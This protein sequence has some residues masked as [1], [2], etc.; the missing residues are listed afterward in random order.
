MRCGP[1]ERGRNFQEFSSSCAEAGVDRDLGA[2]N[3]DSRILAFFRWTSGQENSL[4]GPRACT[5]QAPLITIDAAGA[6]ARQALS[7]LAAA[8]EHVELHDYTWAWCQ[9]SSLA[10]FDPPFGTFLLV[11][12]AAST[13]EAM[14]LISRTLS[15]SDDARFRLLISELAGNLP[16]AEHLDRF[17]GI[18]SACRATPVICLGGSGMGPAE[19][20]QRVLSALLLSLINSSYGCVDWDDFALMFQ[21]VPGGYAVATWVDQGELPESRIC[22]DSAIALEARRPAA[23]VKSSFCCRI[24]KEGYGLTEWESLCVVLDQLAFSDP[25]LCGAALSI[26]K[27]AAGEAGISAGLCLLEVLI[28]HH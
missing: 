16:V 9:P 7:R 28:A 27:A 11:D 1:S 4:L 17:C 15:V 21:R 20:G 13:D 14:A 19:V 26:V 3:L 18:V 23:L 24:A 8:L 5:L 22:G 12:N 25:E 10:G 2:G 6:N